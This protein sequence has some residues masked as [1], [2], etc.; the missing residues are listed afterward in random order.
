MSIDKTDKAEAMTRRG[1]LSALL[2]AGLALGCGSSGN[3]SGTSSDG[4]PDGA[5][6]P[7][8]GTVGDTGAGDAGVCEVTPEGEIGPYFADDSATGF[9]RSSIVSNLD[10]TST[11]PGVP[12]TLSVTVVDAK[13]GCTP[14]V[15]AQIDI[16]HCNASGVYSDISSEETSSDQ[17]LRGYQLTDA[18]GQVTFKTI[19]PGWYSGRTTHIH[20]RVRSS[21][22]E[23]SSTSDGTNTTQCFFD[24]TFIDTLYTTVSPYSAEGKNPTTNASDRVYS[25]EED[26]ANLLTLTGDNTNG[27]AASVTIFLPITATY[28]AAT[29]GGGGPGGGPDDGGFPGEGGPGGGGP[30]GQGGPEDSGEPG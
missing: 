21:Y 14:Y 18:N 25:Q 4:G 17:W 1:A 5:S 9:N 10:G 13:N 30:P 16:W 26:G 11:Q 2:G 19:I 20:L 29:P 7:D 22:S 24:Q 28:D 3:A 27:Y 12:L 8:A 15:G 23:A 6:N